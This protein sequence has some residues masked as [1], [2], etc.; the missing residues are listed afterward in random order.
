[1]NTKQQS[2]NASIEHQVHKHANTEHRAPNTSSRTTSTEHRALNHS[3][4]ERHFKK[5]RKHM[6]HIVEAH[7]LTEIPSTFP[8]KTS[9]LLFQQILSSFKRTIMVYMCESW[10]LKICFMFLKFGRLSVLMWV[11]HRFVSMGWDK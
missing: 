5:K 9:C 11:F 1:M 2:P 4:I 8:K 6:L 3:K 10:E 7:Y